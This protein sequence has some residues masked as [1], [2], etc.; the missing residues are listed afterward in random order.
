MP[1]VVL[2]LDSDEAEESSQVKKMERVI[3]SSAESALIALT[4]AGEIKTVNKVTITMPGPGSSQVPDMTGVEG[5][6]KQEPMVPQQQAVSSIKSNANSEE[7]TG[8]IDFPHGSEPNVCDAN[9]TCTDSE[10]QQT[11]KTMNVNKKYFFAV[12]KCFKLRRKRKG[13]FLNTGG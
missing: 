6:T 3:L 2:V 12:L 9:A 10:G 13:L 5:Q 4:F 8:S 11:G 1:F 7:G